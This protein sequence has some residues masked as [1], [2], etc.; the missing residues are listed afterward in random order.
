VLNDIRVCLGL[1]SPRARWRWLALVPL[2][3]ASAAAEAVGAGAAFAL[4]TILGDPARAA[5]LPVAGWIHARLPWQDA[6]SVILA[7]TLV[8]MVFYVARNALLAGVTWVQEQALND[9]VRDLSHR[10]L[11]AYLAAP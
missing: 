1:L 6:P 7:F 2:A 11:G 3:V 10:L 4:I 9:A 8:V 5:G